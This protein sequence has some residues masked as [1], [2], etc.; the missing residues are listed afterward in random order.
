MATPNDI[1]KLAIS[2]LGY[3]ESPSGSNKTKYGKEY[4]MDGQ[5][6]C[7]MFVWWL[8][9]HCKASNLFYGGKKCKKH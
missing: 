6:W 2:Q 9:K 1:V 4:G 8:F 7:A 5:P 3:K